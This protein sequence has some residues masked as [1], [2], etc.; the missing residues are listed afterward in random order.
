M[1]SGRAAWARRARYIEL[2][3]SGLDRE[4]AAKAVGLGIWDATARHYEN[5]YEAVRDGKVPF[6]AP[7]ERRN[8]DADTDV[9]VD[10]AVP[11]DD[12]RREPGP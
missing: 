5:W 1:V 4:E 9:G 8:D 12:P 7:P 3:Q 11:A 10:V 6:P 2:R